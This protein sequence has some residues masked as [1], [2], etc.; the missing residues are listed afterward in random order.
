MMSSK[1]IGQKISKFCE[2]YNPHIQ[3]VHQILSIR[4]TKK[5]RKIIIK[6]LKISDKEKNLM[7]TQ[8]RHFY[9]IRK[10]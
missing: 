10:E 8:K 2:N 1:H 3:E 4:S 6:F 7:S 5:P 9:Y